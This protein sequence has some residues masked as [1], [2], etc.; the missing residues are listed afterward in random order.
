MVGNTGA[1]R[2]FVEGRHK[3]KIVIIVESSRSTI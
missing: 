3:G 2:Y 1:F